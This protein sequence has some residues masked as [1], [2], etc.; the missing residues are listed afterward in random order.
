MS[1][2]NYRPDP[3]LSDFPMFYPHRYALVKNLFTNRIPANASA[4]KNIDKKRGSKMTLFM[5]VLSFYS[6][7]S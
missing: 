4:M 1:A 7:A 5:S 3:N 2:Q 6:A